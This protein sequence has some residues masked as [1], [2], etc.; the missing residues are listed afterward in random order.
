MKTSQEL[1]QDLKLAKQKEK[2]D[3]L[4]EQLSKNLHYKNMKVQDH[5]HC[6]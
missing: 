2:E 1:E 5:M 4:N 3:N 6:K